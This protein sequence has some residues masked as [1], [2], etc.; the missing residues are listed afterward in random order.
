[1]HMGGGSMTFAAGP[2]VAVGPQPGGV[3]QRAARASRGAAPAGIVP[4][5]MA[6]SLRPAALR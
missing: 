1:M 5:L 6:P 4:I 2:G 3:E